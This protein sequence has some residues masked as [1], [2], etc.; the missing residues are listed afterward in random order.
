MRQDEWL[1]GKKGTHNVKFLTENKTKQIMPR[2]RA[3]GNGDGKHVC[4]QPP[5]QAVAAHAAHNQRRLHQANEEVIGHRQMGFGLYRT[6]QMV[7]PHAT[8]LRR[9][10]VLRRTNRAEISDFP[11]LCSAFRTS[12][13]RQSWFYSA[14]T[15]NTPQ[16]I[17]K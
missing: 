16:S 7:F 5:A 17:R 13:R 4:L 8:F 11:Y 3:K 15:I 12:V 1:V 10:H 9:N 14:K 6:H 2:T